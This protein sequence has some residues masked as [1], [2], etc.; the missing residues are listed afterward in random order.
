MKNVFFTRAA[1][2]MAL[3]IPIALFVGFTQQ[4]FFSYVD[5]NTIRLSNFYH[6]EENSLDVVFLGASE[7]FTGVSPGQFYEEAGLTSYLY[8]MDANPGTLYTHQLKEVLKTQS[9]QLI[10]VEVNGFLYKDEGLMN[11]EARL[12]VF[13]DSMPMSLNKL[14]TIFRFDYEDKLSCL[15]PFIK[16]HGDWQDRDTLQ[17]RHSRKTA[18][19]TPS[20]L[21][22]MV[23]NGVLDAELPV[24]DPSDC[25]PRELPV[26]AQQ[27]LNEFLTLCK[28]ENLRVLF[29]RFPHKLTTEADWECLGFANRLGEI[30]RAE[31]FDFLNLE[32]ETAAMGLADLEDYYNPHHLNT[33]GQRKLTDWLG[34]WI[35][36]TYSL[37]PLPQNEENRAHWEACAAYDNSAKAYCEASIAE[38][39]GLWVSDE[40]W[41]IRPFEEFIQANQ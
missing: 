30:V 12:R 40:A 29:V 9:P 41:H 11:D 23:T 24:Y 17:Y 18:P 39:T 36:D 25:A 27:K 22:G 3:L 1:K 33:N 8:A 14:E 20:L 19:D 28:D 26:L 37:T 13:T 31:G 10:V 4:Y 38:G 34:S 7:V 6:E 16:F 15:L 35:M 32:L 2:L 5:V 21:K